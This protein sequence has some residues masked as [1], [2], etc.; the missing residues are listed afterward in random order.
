M[1]FYV[2]SLVDKLKFSKQC[3]ETIAV[4]NKNDL[5][6]GCGFAESVTWMLTLACWCELNN[7]KGRGSGEGGFTLQSKDEGFVKL[8]ILNILYQQVRLKMW[9]LMHIRKNTCIKLYR[10]PTVGSGRPQ[11]LPSNW[12]PLQDVSTFL[13]EIL[14]DSALQG[15]YT[16]YAEVLGWS[17]TSI[18]QSRRRIVQ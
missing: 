1:K 4:L 7:E 2:H 10:L 8:L 5:N 16:H 11:L 13:R 14:E 9:H 3:A 6:C 15:C 12:N 18:Y 17:E